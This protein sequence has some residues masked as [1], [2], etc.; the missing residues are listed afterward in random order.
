[1][2]EAKS[3][4]PSYER[5]RRL[6]D[7]LTLIR[8]ARLRLE[9]RYDQAARRN[10]MILTP[11][12]AYP[13]D[14]LWEKRITDVGSREHRVERRLAVAVIRAAGA[15]VPNFMRTCE[16]D[17]PPVLLRLGDVL[18]VVVLREQSFQKA[19]DPCVFLLDASALVEIGPATA[20]AREGLR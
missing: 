3:K 18:I 20:A 13:I 2:S 1:M 9:E 11:E 4:T 7:R 12:E 19:P 17:C 6:A 8:T 15:K 14:E 5:L 10:H 16:E